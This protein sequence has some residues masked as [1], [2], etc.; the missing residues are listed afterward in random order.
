MDRISKNIGPEFRKVRLEKHLTIDKVCE[1]IASTATLSRWERGKQNISAKTYYAFLKRVHVLDKELEKDDYDL[2]KT[3][4]QLNILYMECKDKEL[5]D[6]SKK[7]LINYFDTKQFDNLLLAATAT[8]LYYDRT[9]N[10]ITDFK[11]KANLSLQIGN[12]TVWH[13]KDLMLFGNSQLLLDSKVIYRTAKILASTSYENKYVLND[14]LLTLLNAEY[15]LIKKKDIVHAQKLLRTIE[16]L[17]FSPYHH[18]T[19][20]KNKF[21]CKLVK[22]AST[23]DDTDV[24]NYF[25][26]LSNSRDNKQLLEDFKTSFS[27]I[28][29]LYEK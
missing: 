10:D 3:M 14:N 1:G 17:N 12:I 28:K 6:L 24:L 4:T 20:Y 8:N 25:S 5:H 23:L 18:T 9:G 29:Q 16:R 15:S 7:L 27:Q 21:I 2:N 11:F 19:M 26:E 22:Y 13:D